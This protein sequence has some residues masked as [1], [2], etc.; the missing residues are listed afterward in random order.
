MEFVRKSSSTVAKTNI[1]KITVTTIS[2]CIVQNRM[3][4]MPGM[5]GLFELSL[6]SRKVNDKLMT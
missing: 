6:Y 1:L 4:L 3:L 2:Y 5:L